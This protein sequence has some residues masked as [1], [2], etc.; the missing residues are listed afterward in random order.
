M[1]REVG[2][3]YMKRRS[4]KGGALTA[5]IPPALVTVGNREESNVLTVAWTGILATVPPKTY[6]SVRPSRHSHAIL[7]R[8]REFVINLPSASLAREVDF[9]GIYPGGKMDKFERCGFT[10]VESEAVEPPTIAECPLSIECRVSDV[11][12]MGSHD[13]FIA[14][15]LSVSCREEFID[16]EGKLR[17]DK[18]D[19]LAYAH[20]EY[21]RLGERLGRLGFSTDKKKRIS[22]EQK[23]PDPKIEKRPFYEG[24]KKGKS[25]KPQNKDKGR[26]H[27]KRIKKKVEE[28]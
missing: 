26:P 13:V 16:G 21:Y 27:G 4:L 1:K 8:G 18:M 22:S 25:T 15:I 24:M 2:I 20:G 9:A 23:A 11:L 14:D 7:S 19:L 3:R 10:R 12:P 5:P 17:F 28:E 6:I